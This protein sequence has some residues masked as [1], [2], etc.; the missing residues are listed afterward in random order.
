MNIKDWRTQRIKHLGWYKYKV[1]EIQENGVSYEE[2]GM[3]QPKKAKDGSLLK[4]PN[5]LPIEELGDDI[6]WKNIIP[7]Y[8]KQD[9]I[10]K[11][12]EKK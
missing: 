2:D 4:L 8:Y 12:T 5:I 6:K 10:N 11:I 1:L 9:I 7:S 3:R